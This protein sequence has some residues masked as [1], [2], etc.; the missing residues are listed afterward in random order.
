MDTHMHMALEVIRNIK[1]QSYQNI[2]LEENE[3]YNSSSA[4][5]TSSLSLNEEENLF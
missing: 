5:N 2:C 3:A 4:I 1:E